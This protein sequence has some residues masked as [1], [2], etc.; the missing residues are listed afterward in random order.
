[1]IDAM[2]QHIYLLFHVLHLT[3][4][5]LLLTAQ[6]LHLIQQLT[7]VLLPYFSLFTLHNGDLNTQTNRHRGLTM[8]TLLVCV[9]FIS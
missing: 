2:Y 5:V 7:Q 9:C 8:C 3:L 1:M 6:H 4:H